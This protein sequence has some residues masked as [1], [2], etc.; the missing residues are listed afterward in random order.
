[1]ENTD[2]LDAEYFRGVLAAL[3]VVYAHHHPTAVLPVEIVRIVGA[4]ELFLFAS[5]P[6]YAYEKLDYLK[7]TVVETKRT[8]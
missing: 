7:K 8:H 5:S 6:G 3:N 4:D 2:E 1:M